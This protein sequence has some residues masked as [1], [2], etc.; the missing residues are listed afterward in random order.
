MN[1]NLLVVVAVLFV[2][3]ALTYRQSVGR[4]DRFQRGQL[5]LANLNPDAVAPIRVTKGEET[6]TLKR[7]GDRFLVA[8]ERDFPASNS[9]VNKLL[10]D[11]LEIGLEREIGRGADLQA[12]LEIE[13]VGTETIAVDLEAAGSQS[14]VQMRIGRAF[15]DG[16]GHYIQRFDEPEAPIYLT[17]TS[18][19]VATDLSSYLDKVIVDH[20]GVEVAVVVGSDFRLE[21]ATEGEDLSLKDQP[22]GKKIRASEVGRLE[23]ALSGLRFDDVFVA[24]AGEIVGLQFDRVLEIGLF[25][26]SSYRLSVAQRDERSFLRIEGRNE[27][28]QVAITV[29]EAEDE[30]REKAEMLS[31]ADE[32]DEFNRFQGSWVYEISE[33]TANKLLL[34]RADL[35]ETEAN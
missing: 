16:P 33:F 9:A 17:S 14:M 25:D 6:V 19:Q 31:R 29:D 23:T 11:L 18:V 24:D 4:A 32:I 26:G 7:Q 2:L 22:A 34:E 13:P 5:F 35:I 8:E 10:R 27:I 20:E 3:S 1:R 21:R 12:E 15:A 30:L 28:Q